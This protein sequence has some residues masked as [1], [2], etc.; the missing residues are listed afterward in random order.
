MYIKA[1]TGRMSDDIVVRAIKRELETIPVE[2][3]KSNRPLLTHKTCTECIEKKPI[4]LFRPLTLNL[5][6][7]IN[8]SGRCRMC[9]SQ[10]DQERYKEKHPTSKGKRGPKSIFDDEELCESIRNRL[11]TCSVRSIASELGLRYTTLF[12]A[13]KRGVFQLE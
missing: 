4:E 11:G 1:L 12:A 7:Q 5:K 13:Y 6:G 8:Y 3:S 10:Y 2:L 9:L